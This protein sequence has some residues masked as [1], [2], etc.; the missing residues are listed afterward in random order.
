MLVKQMI[1]AHCVIEL[2]IKMITFNLEMQYKLEIIATVLFTINRCPLNHVINLIHN[3]K[4]QRPP[5]KS[6]A[7]SLIPSE[8]KRFSKECKEINYSVY[9]CLFT[10]LL[11][12]KFASDWHQSS[13]FPVQQRA[14]IARVDFEHGQFDIMVAC[15]CLWHLCADSPA[16][17]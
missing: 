8:A 12:C 9:H 15:V 17:C 16:E 5:G 4:M 13:P 7:G 10:V 3:M 2:F 6:C 1:M 14:H 11:A